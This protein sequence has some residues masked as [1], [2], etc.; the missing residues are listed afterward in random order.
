MIDM[1]VLPQERHTLGNTAI[2]QLA[3]RS[4]FRRTHF[5]GGLNVKEMVV[6]RSDC[7]VVADVGRYSGLAC[8]L[9]ISATNVCELW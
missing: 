1:W 3:D 7:D 8:H 2:T 5:F 9:R 6:A 4:T